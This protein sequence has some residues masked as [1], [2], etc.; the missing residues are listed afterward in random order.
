MPVGE[1]PWLHARLQGFYTLEFYMP[2]NVN[3]QSQ[4]MTHEIDGKAFANAC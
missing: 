2:A 3:F 1:K 4:Q